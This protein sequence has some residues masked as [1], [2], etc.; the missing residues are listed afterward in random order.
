MAQ[1]RKPVML[2]SIG[3]DSAV[4]L[5]LTLKTFY[6]GRLPLLLLHVDTG[7]KF[8]EMI[9]F[10]D[11]IAAD[12]GLERLVHTNPN[13]VAQGGPISHGSAVHTDIMRTQGLK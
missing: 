2:Y 5:H 11:K 1:F 8:R 7:W 9:G 4:M 10:R 6:P 13:G 12:L 3:K